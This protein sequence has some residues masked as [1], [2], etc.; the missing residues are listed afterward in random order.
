MN[1]EF[2][3]MDKENFMNFL[4]NE[5]NFKIP[6]V[7]RK[8]IAAWSAL[9]LL[10][11]ILWAL[12]TF[13]NSII[14][15]SNPILFLSLIIA[16]C[17]AIFRFIHAQY[18]SIY[19]ISAQ[20]EVVKEIIFNFCSNNDVFF[21]DNEISSYEDYKN[22][23][24]VKIKFETKTNIKK[25]NKNWHPLWIVLY[26]WTDILYRLFANKKRKPISSFEKSEASIYSLIIILIIFYSIFICTI[27]PSEQTNIQQTKVIPEQTVFTRSV[28]ENLGDVSE[29]KKDGY[30]LYCREGSYADENREF[31]F[32]RVDEAVERIKEVLEIEKLPAGFFI[33]MLGSREEMERIIGDN[34]KGIALREENLALFVYNPEIRPYFRHELF[35]LIAY[36]VWGKSKSGVLEE[37]GAMFTDNECLRY[38]N[39]VTVINRYLY[40]KDKLFEFEELVKN[41]SEKAAENDM[42]AYLESA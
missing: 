42:I 11:A 40:G 36:R 37:G 21:K 26:L 2:V 6:W 38:E 1:D 34:Y 20:K 16:V 30:I 31:L 7:Q 25:V 41:F 24:E 8:E 9:L 18:I 5:H 39:P 3:K 19:N 32:T 29:Y 22:Y 13:E 35:H 14:I 23:F 28:I 17:Y 15:K 12:T 4:L 27:Y 10:F 33:V